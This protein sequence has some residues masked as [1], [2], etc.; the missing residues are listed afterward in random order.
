MNQSKKTTTTVVVS[1]PQ[2]KSNGRS[3]RR[4]R[5]GRGKGGVIVMNGRKLK[6]LRQLPRLGAGGRSLGLGQDPT[7]AQWLKA[8]NDPFTHFPPRLGLGCMLPT[9]ICSPF[10]KGSFTT[11]ADGSFQLWVNPLLFDQSN[12]A[13]GSFVSIDVAGHGTNATFAVGGNQLPAANGPTINGSFDQYRVIAGAVRISALQALTAAPGII[14][15]SVY[16]QD[17][18]GKIPTGTGLTPTNCDALS[19]YP[20]MESSRSID[21][22]QVNWRPD[23]QLCLESF[24][25]QGVAVTNNTA[26]PSLLVVGIGLPASTTIFYQVLFHLEAYDVS[27]GVI[28]GQ[29]DDSSFGSTA[30]ETISGMFRSIATALSPVTETVVEQ[31]SIN[32]QTLASNAMAMGTKYAFNQAMRRYGGNSMYRTLEYK[33][34]L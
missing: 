1:G 20:M 6:N 10:I 17:Q 18:N 11:N 9:E 12:A 19:K 8:L 21:P 26:P 13:N 27:Q 23:S 25:P 7:A 33:S 29:G 16:P 31:A 32:A 28:G 5:R 24:Q 4:R 14:Y 22:L 30:F 3:R 15:S 2:V 34:N